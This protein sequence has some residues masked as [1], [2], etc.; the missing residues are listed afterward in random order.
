MP[1][2]VCVS[3][4]PRLFLELNCVSAFMHISV[5]V[6]TCVCAYMF[7]CV[8]VCVCVCMYMGVRICSANKVA[9]SVSFYLRYRHSV[10]VL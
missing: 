10:S 3:L 9:V 6:C 7:F 2:Y 8:Q 5:C 1:V 4:V